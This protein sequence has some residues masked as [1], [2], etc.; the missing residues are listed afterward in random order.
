MAG[1]GQDLFN[2]GVLS[3]T[4]VMVAWTIAWMRKHGAVMAVE[5]RDAGARIRSG[6]APLYLLAVTIGVAVLRDGSELVVFLSALSLSGQTTLPGILGGFI[7]GG[8][9]GAVIGALIYYGVLRAGIKSVFQLAAVLLAMLGAGLAAQAAG[10]L[11]SA[12]WLPPLID[13]IWDSSMLLPD[14]S[15]L[16]QLA[17][18]LF[19]YISQ[20][21]A[22]Q[23][24]IYAAVLA[25]ICWLGLRAPARRQRQPAA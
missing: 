21:S 22:V 17:H 19:G 14:E 6:Q 20:P 8:A 11:V 3:L 5:A 18:A 4:V 16:G 10:F 7:V 1:R 23:V 12:G 2:A 15:A 9:A 24:A 25:A 13:P